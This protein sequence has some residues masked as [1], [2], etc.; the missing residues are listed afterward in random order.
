MS[1]SQTSWTDNGWSPTSK[2]PI[3]KSRALQG[4]ELAMIIRKLPVLQLKRYSVNSHQDQ[5]S[6]YS[7]LGKEALSTTGWSTRIYWGL[8]NRLPFFRHSFS[9]PQLTTHPQRATFCAEHW[10]GYH[11]SKTNYCHWRIWR[12][13][14]REVTRFRV[15]SPENIFQAS[16]EVGIFR[17]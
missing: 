16:K 11:M 1:P 14:G 15:P 3:H 6:K 7:Y 2:Y 4:Q 8:G 13:E 17:G 9:Q 10:E 12:K 5:G